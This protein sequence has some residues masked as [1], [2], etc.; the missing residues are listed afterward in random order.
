MGID[1]SIR[2]SAV[3]FLSSAGACVASN[4]SPSELTGTDPQS[5]TGAIFTTDVNG[6]RVNQNIYASKLDVYLNGG[7]GQN[8]PP[9]A[10]S[11]PEG[12][13]YFQV[14]DPSGMTL[15]SSDAI[16][17]REFHVS[18]DGVIVSVPAIA[19]SHN[20][21]VDQ[22]EASLGAITVQLFPYDD[23]P[24]PGDEYKAWVTPVA[25]YSP[26]NGKNGFI[27]ADS[28][29]DNF[30][31]E[32]VLTTCDAQ[33]ATCGSIS[34]GCGGT[35][36]CGTCPDG[37]TCTNNV[38]VCTPTTCEAQHASCGSISDGCGG[39]LCC[40]SCPDGYTCSGDRRDGS[41]SCVPNPCVPDTCAAHW[42][43][44]GT[45]PDGCG[46]TLDCGTCTG[47]YTCGGG[48]T[49]NVCG[50]MPPRR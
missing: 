10:A 20:T 40:G 43:D 3:A 12:D 27:D 13:Y 9:H 17:C 1:R 11:L 32:C 24:N 50:C 41:L 23:T 2:L 19:C 26:G 21:G 28:K 30:K 22:D 25:D 44:C 14:T 7:P 33:M 18:A 38:C 6:A 34:D 29:T 4:P 8:A 15:L 39:T 36:S 48:G 16:Q 42:F 45:I 47:T 31:V 49:P 46:G 5:L 37:D 35:L